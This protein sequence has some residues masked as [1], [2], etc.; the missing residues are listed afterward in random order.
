MFIE[1]KMIDGRM[2]TDDVYSI[3]LHV[4]TTSGKENKTYGGKKYIKHSLDKL[5]NRL[6]YLKFPIPVKNVI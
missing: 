5:I 6:I 3:I 2:H 1:I 4:C